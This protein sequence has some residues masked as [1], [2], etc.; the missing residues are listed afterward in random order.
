VNLLVYLGAFVVS[1]LVLW[2]ERTHRA[3]VGAPPPVHAATRA[4]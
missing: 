3:G 4:G 1:L 2:W